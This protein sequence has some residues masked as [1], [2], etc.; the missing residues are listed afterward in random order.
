MVCIRIL[1][2]IRSLWKACKSAMV[3][4]DVTLL[5][6]FMDLWI[7]NVFEHELNLGWKKIWKEMGD[8]NPSTIAM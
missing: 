4:L 3:G 5:F 1:L 8:L 2:I 7:M 6:N